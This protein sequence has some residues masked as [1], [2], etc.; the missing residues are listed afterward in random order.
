MLLLAMWQAVVVGVGLPE[1]AADGQVGLARAREPFAPGACTATNRRC[2]ATPGGEMEPLRPKP[3]WGEIEQKCDHFTRATW[4]PEKQH[5]RHDMMREEGRLGRKAEGHANAYSCRLKQRYW[6]HT[7]LW[8]RPVGP[9]LL[10]VGGEH[11]LDGSVAGFVMDAAAELSALIV[12]VEH[13]FF[14]S[15]IPEGWN[16]TNGLSLLTMEQAVSDLAVFRD[17]FQRMVIA[18]QG[19][20]ENLWIAVGCG[21]S[22]ALATWARTKH[23]HHFAGAWASSPPLV[24]AV[25]FSSHDIHDR[26]VVGEACAARIRT[27]TDIVEI[28]LN[29]MGPQAATRLKLLLQASEDVS[30]KDLMLI[31]HDSISLAIQHGFKKRLCSALGTAHD[32]EIVIVFAN[33]TATLWGRSYAK[34]C[35][36]NSTCLSDVQKGLSSAR[37]WHWIQCTQLGLF[38]TTP[39]SEEDLGIRHK[40]IDAPFFMRRC[41][42]AFGKGTRTDPHGPRRTFKGSGDKNLLIVTASDDPWKLAANTEQF[43]PD[44]IIEVDCHECGH[45]LDMLPPAV[46]DEV[47]LREARSKILRHLRSWT[48]G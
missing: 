7:G 40:A 31:V 3:E 19:Q 8:S 32:D 18:P 26:Q 16:T 30:N 5:M 27:L 29:N 47:Q 34:S 15:S 22:G 13:R 48:L 46:A 10:V 45:C 43:H 25:D 23:P 11:P 28:E 21:Y 1:R 24:A 36:F 12:V 35:H 4:T 38:A 6:M 37:A 44:E 17:K 42:T 33:F 20:S 2:V 9:V 14:G 39:R 41:V